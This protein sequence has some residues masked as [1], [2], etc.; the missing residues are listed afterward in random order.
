M[1][2]HEARILRLM[3]SERE[4]VQWLVAGLITNK[5]PGVTLDMVITADQSKL[6]ETFRA[7][8][9]MGNSPDL[10]TMIPLMQSDG[11]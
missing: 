7:A 10:K 9:R 11:R 8:A 6:K 1:N 4:G 5:I 3:I 2:Y